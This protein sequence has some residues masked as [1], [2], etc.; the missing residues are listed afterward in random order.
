VVAPASR[1]NEIQSNLLSLL[2][3]TL[4]LDGLALPLEVAAEHDGALQRSRP[5]QH[6]QGSRSRRYYVFH[7]CTGD[8]E[9]VSNRRRRRLIRHL[10]AEAQR[11]AHEVHALVHAVLQRR[12]GLL[13]GVRHE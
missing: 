6:Q 11:G 2:Q 4:H 8:T 12:A 1:R 13:R 3:R 9:S 7:R 5:L 10:A